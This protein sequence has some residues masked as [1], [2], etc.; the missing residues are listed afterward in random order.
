[1]AHTCSIFYM[2][3]LQL[4][5]RGASLRS[6]CTDRS[7]CKRRHSRK[8][9]G[10]E[11]LEFNT[12]LAL[13]RRFHRHQVALA[14]TQ[15]PKHPG[16]LGFGSGLPVKTAW[17]HRTFRPW[18]LAL[19]AVVVAVSHTEPEGNRNCNCT[20]SAADTMLDD[21]LQIAMHPVRPAR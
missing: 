20:A 4:Q 15:V 16:R 11:P 19:L 10:L 12:T 13:D 3:Q 8:R 5:P 6:L 2:L 18:A 1:M 7:N 17:M 14:R 21:A 9:C